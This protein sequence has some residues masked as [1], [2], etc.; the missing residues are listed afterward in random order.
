[1]KSKYIFIAFTLFLIS[2]GPLLAQGVPADAPPVAI[3]KSILNLTE[4]QIAEIGGLIE[5][6]AEVVGPI[7]E[8]IHQLQRQLE[9]EVNSDAPDPLE[10]GDLV[11][12]VRMLRHEISQHQENFRM[13]FELLLTPSQREQ[14]AHIHRIALATRAAQ[15]LAQ[16]GLR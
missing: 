5:T 11:L 15:A 2:N 12:E 14:I 7:T 13:A 16:L 3:L 10:V 9:E 6:R 8:Q 1:M 4:D